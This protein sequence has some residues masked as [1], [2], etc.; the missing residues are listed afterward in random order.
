MNVVLLL[1]NRLWKDALL[2]AKQQIG[3]C[4][5]IRSKKSLNPM[6]PAFNFL[7]TTVFHFASVMYYR[8]KHKIGF[9]LELP[10]E[11]QIPPFDSRFK[12][13]LFLAPPVAN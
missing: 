10:H 9:N 7:D 6:Y 13:S 1:L 4:F 12:A 2:Y 11:V 8:R 3:F 5:H